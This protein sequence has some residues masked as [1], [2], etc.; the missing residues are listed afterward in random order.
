MRIYV[1]Y[2][3]KLF[4]T[5]LFLLVIGIVL[6][7][8]QHFLTVP[9]LVRTP[10]TYYMAN[11]QE[12]IVALTFDDGPDPI[13]T[14]EVLNI[15]KEKDVHATF[16][17]LGDAGQL[18]TDLLKR[19][20]KDGHEIGNHGFNHDYQQIHLV[21][22]I[23]KTDNIVFSATGSHTLYYRPPGGLVSQTQLATIKQHGHIVALWSVDSKD[24]MNPG[25]KPI[26]NNV[27][28]N[29]FPGSII[30][31]HDGGYQ[32]TQTVKSLGPIIDEL[33]ARGYRFAT[34]SELRALDSETK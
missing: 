2:R 12:N 9:S 1:L 11:T 29:V 16:F 22:E 19:I 32:R 34:L 21:E 4:L 18:Y 23:N 5:F 26:Q 14:P 25:V 8:T 28:K 20:A 6:T 17:I 31:M 15:L 27:L 30:L 3:R 24:W 13:D 10:G 33:K 7:T